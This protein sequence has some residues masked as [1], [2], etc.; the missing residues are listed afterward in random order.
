M[1]VTSASIGE[2]I[3]VRP[4]GSELKA[5]QL[6]TRIKTEAL[7][8]FQLIVPSGQLVPTHELQGDVVVH[9]LEG[10][11][12]LK[13]LGVIRDL[14]A[15]ELLCFYSNEPFSVKGIEATSLLITVAR[16]SPRENEQ[17]IG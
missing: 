1:L 2:V 3:Q 6:V 13:A 15:G 17:L 5:A 9:C 4:V 7:E 14:K 16:T 12:S 8:I 11:V 10:R